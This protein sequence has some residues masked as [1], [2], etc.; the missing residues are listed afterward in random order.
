MSNASALDVVVNAKKDAAKK[1]A[2]SFNEEVC[3]LLK[4]LPESLTKNDL[5]WFELACRRKLFGDRQRYYY[6]LESELDC[7]ILAVLS[8]PDWRRPFWELGVR[9]DLTSMTTS[10]DDRPSLKEL[11]KQGHVLLASFDREESRVNSRVEHVLR[12]TWAKKGSFGKHFL[13][14]VN[15]A[16]SNRRNVGA[17]KVLHYAFSIAESIMDNGGIHLLASVGEVNANG[18]VYQICDWLRD[19]WR[20]GVSGRRIKFTIEL[21]S[22]AKYAKLGK[23]RNHHAG[24]Y[25][26]TVDAKGE[27]TIYRLVSG[28]YEKYEKQQSHKCCVE[29]SEWKRMWVDSAC[30]REAQKLGV[31]F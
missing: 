9:L 4:E 2:D 24:E 1:V 6:G 10:E 23:D 18:D 17:H 25:V 13:R 29:N 22:S 7:D 15:I 12:Q 28:R 30:Y 19:E 14:I 8:I 3:E 16:A 21:K 5:K 11:R 27:E 20:G 31:K 26:K